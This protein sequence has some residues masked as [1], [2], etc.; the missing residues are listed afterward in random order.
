[1]E[2]ALLKFSSFHGAEITETGGKQISGSFIIAYSTMLLN[3]DTSFS[4]IVA[5]MPD[6]SVH[7]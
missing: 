5:Y 4:R 1:M 7:T 6:N 2:K 3:T